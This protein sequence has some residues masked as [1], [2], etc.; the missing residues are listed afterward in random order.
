MSAVLRIF[1]VAV[2]ALVLPLPCFS[3]EFWTCGSSPLETHV[4][5][6]RVQSQNFLVDA[7][8]QEIAQKIA[9]YAEFYRKD[10][11]VAWLGQE[12]P[13]WRQPCTLKVV[14]TQSGSG[15]ATSFSFNGGQ[16]L[17]QEMQVQGSLE[18]ILSCVLPHEVTHTVFAYR[19]R[20]PLPRW[21]DE[22]AAVLSE[23]EKEK[24][25][26][27][28]ICRDRL[29]SEKA[30]PA[31]QLLS[32]MEYPRDVMALYA[33]GYCLTAYLVELGGR[34]R[35]LQFVEAGMAN[36]W[37]TAVKTCYPE[38]KSV[39]YLDWGWRVWM[40][41]GRKDKSQD[42]GP[43]KDSVPPYYGS[44][45][46]TV[47]Q[48]NGV[49]VTTLPATGVQQ[50]S[51]AGSEEKLLAALTRIES[52]VD[53]VRASTAKLKADVDRHEK[54][55]NDLRARVGRLEGT[56]GSS[57]VSTGPTVPA[58]NSPPERQQAVVRPA[59]PIFAQ[60]TTAPP[61]AQPLGSYFGMPPNCQPG[62]Q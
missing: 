13:T 58:W 30:I 7:P 33:Q 20:R 52:K 17:G 28:R 57:G 3:G 6:Y 24:A 47:R 18:R 46:N 55:I 19:F 4:A 51:A 38:Y 1:A 54:D 8:S 27:D 60:P 43:V 53:E 62:R 42:G 14:I 23:D 22:G 25:T 40:R 59:Q 36:G 61:S 35:F 41:D 49:A 39:E 31:R 21:A 10:R 48:P 15:G 26:H 34:A 37:D 29:N 9:Q 32:M 50:T 44:N 56:G 5:A 11:A 12:M 45:G 16:V 2:L